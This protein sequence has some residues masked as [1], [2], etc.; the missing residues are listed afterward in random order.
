[1]AF[2]L[3]VNP[4]TNFAGTRSFLNEVFRSRIRF[5]PGLD[6][7]TRIE[8][9][10]NTRRGGYLNLLE[11]ST[12]L[13]DEAASL[14]SEPFLLS[15][16]GYKVF[17]VRKRF[18]NQTRTLRVWFLVKGRGRGFVVDELEDEKSQPILIGNLV[19][20]IE[21]DDETIQTPSINVPIQN[22]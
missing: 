22:P 10:P 5:A 9:P 1:M 18:N 21:T 3:G 16:D 17:I 8:E 6:F 4:Y 13:D 15:L 20:T 12:D 11:V 19:L 14:A 7:P 2:T